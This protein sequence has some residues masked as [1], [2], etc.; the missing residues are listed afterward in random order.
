MTRRVFVSKRDFTR[1]LASQISE[2]LAWVGLESIVE[3][4]AHVFIK[5]NLTWSEPIAGVTTS[6]EFIEAVLAT[7]RARTPNIVIGESNGGYHSY[8]AEEAFRGHRVYEIAE[9]Y[10]TQ[11]VNLSR[12]PVE[13]VEIVVGG[14]EV[15]VELPSLLL[16]DVDVFVTLPVPKL[17]AMTWVSLAFKNQWGCQPNTMRLRDHS[18]FDKKIIAINR[19]VKPRLAVYD[20]TYFLD[21]NGPMH[22]EAVRMDLLIV[23]NDIG[24]GDAVCCSL[25]QIDPGKVKHYRLAR[26]EGMFP[27]SLEEITLYQSIEVFQ[28]RA[29][30]L[31]RS[32]VNWVALSAF[33]SRWLTYMLYESAFGDLAHKILYTIRKNKLIGRVLH[34]ELGPPNVSGTSRPPANHTS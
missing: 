28:T 24:A 21:K 26:A 4:G 31:D 22:G 13:Q 17:H 6:P 23:A 1:N 14:R 12:M 2:G 16:H 20:G 18:L 10:G 7:L 9:R 34:G 25:M 30:K 8:Q 19:L 11:V 29:F 3:R 15:S 5:P 32:L 27:S 33:N